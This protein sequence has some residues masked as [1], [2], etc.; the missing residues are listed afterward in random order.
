MERSQH[1]RHADAEDDPVAALAVSIG[2]GVHCA[3]PGVSLY[4]PGTH[5]EH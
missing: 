4:V 3:S 1:G 2:H 5:G